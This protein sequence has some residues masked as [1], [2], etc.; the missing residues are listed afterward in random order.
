MVAPALAADQ[1]KARQT[2]S[3]LIFLDESGFSQSPVVRRTW[4]P[5][6]QTPILIAPFNWKRL[7]AIASLITTLSLRQVGLCLRLHSGSIK[8]P[9]LIEYLRALKRHLRGR[10]AILLWDR[11]P[12][13]RGGKVQAELRRHAR[14]LSV[15]W[16]PA[17]APE[18]N[19]VEYVW[20]YL[21]GTD[22]ANFVSDDLTGIGRQVRR[23]TNRIR[24]RPNL[25][26]SFIKH[27]GLF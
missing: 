10:K 3:R 25:G 9:Q 16:L 11:L 22:L 13:H 7:S 6:G 19:P 21:D 4:S 12:V 26:R 27:S 24:H 8:Q 18:L 5:R 15:E 20:A 1:K 14:W 2:R 17:Y 23:A